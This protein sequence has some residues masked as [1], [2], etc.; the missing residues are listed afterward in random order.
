MTSRRDLTIIIV[1]KGNHPKMA[2]RFK[3]VK[4]YDLPRTMNLL[5]VWN[6]DGL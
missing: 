6:M 1:S 2:A 3:L 5:V 4:Y